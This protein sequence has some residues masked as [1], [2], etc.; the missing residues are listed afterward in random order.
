MTFTKQIIANLPTSSV[1]F[2]ARTN[3]LKHHYQKNSA[4]EFPFKILENRDG[5][6]P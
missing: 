1:P 5:K 6:N 2:K 4:T 3:N